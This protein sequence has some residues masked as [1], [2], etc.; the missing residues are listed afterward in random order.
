MEKLPLVT[1]ICVCYNHA[2]FVKEAIQSVLY[3]TYKPIELIVTDDASSDGSQEVIRSI[4][5]DFTFLPNE[6]NLGYCKTFNRALAFA[7][8][9]YI[10]DLAADDVLL[11]D[12]VAQ[13]VA[14]FSSLPKNVGVVYSNCLYIDQNGRTLSVF[15]NQKSYHPK[16]LSGYIYP[17][18]LGLN[19]ISTPTMMIRREVLDFTGGYD[20][21]LVFEDYDFW[22][23]SAKKYQY[24]YLDTITT[25]KRVL[26]G[27][28]SSRFYV[29]GSSTH[30]ESLIKILKR[31]LAYCI[32]NR[33]DLKDIKSTIAY[34]T[35]LGLLTEHFAAVNELLS[36]AKKAKM[37]SFFIN[38]YSLLAKMRLKLY[39]LYK[40]F[41]RIKNLLFF[42]NKKTDS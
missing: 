35:R 39:S 4:E 32:E 25:K 18:V 6:H 14:L 9:E 42:R 20:E 26:E 1:V 3:Q 30:Y 27:S 19:F 38:F 31:E 16:P 41:S 8:G 34:Y 22:A 21:E 28:M 29:P 37:N 10:I 36:L 40:I 13:Q 17:Q 11:P 24:V 7:K 15:H 5:G 12:R 33:I 23:K 2:K